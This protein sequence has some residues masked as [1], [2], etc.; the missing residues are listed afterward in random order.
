MRKRRNYTKRKSKMN[1]R[2]TKRRNIKR[3][4]A[5]RRNTKRR[6]TK[7]RN[8]KRINEILI[9]EGGM[10]TAKAT[11]SA[12]A[13]ATASAGK[14]CLGCLGREPEN[15]TTEVNVQ[16][17]RSP[18]TY[19]DKKAV[20]NTRVILDNFDVDGLEGNRLR[21]MTKDSWYGHNQFNAER[22]L[23]QEV[24]KLK[25]IAELDNLFTDPISN[26]QSVDLKMTHDEMK[27]IID[28]NT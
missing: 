13:K 11:A 19:A 14:A 24:K 5:K 6:N 26:D 21:Q 23:R 28:I 20:Q 2:N 7:R 1:R 22:P 18:T 8:T 25:A 27:E 12:A 16:P 9:Q 17:S 3:T 15:E 10:E 4:N